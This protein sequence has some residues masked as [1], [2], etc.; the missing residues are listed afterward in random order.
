MLELEG[1]EHAYG[2]RTV[3]SVGRWEVAS[4]ARRAVVG[5]SGSGKTTLLAILAGLVRATR[6]TLR[7][8]GIA[9]GSLGAAAL[10]RWRARHVG[11]VMQSPHLLPPLDA[12]ENVT[13]A[14]HLAG[15]AVDAGRARGL[16]DTLGV[17]G[18]ARAKPAELSRGE[19]QR[20]AIAR[21]VVNRP[22]LLLAD[23]PTANLDDAA[24]AAVLDLFERAAGEA[25]LIVA[26]HDARV[27]ARYPERLELG[28]AA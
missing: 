1:L 2:A 6:G 3:L 27:K 25:I 23:E 24:C 13:L 15:E 11:I 8:D 5:P 17:G 12:V 14:Q 21:A 20:V 18:R 10:D 7:V 4:G 19:Q 9:V 26:T 28:G 16:L 22:K